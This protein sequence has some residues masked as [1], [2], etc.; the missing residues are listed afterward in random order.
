MSEHKPAEVHAK[1][2]MM[3]ALFEY[4]AACHVDN[5]L[6]ENPIEHDSSLEFA[7]PP[8]FDKKMKKIIARHD[9]KETLK[10]LRK[11]TIKYLPKAAIFLLVLIGS[12]TIVVA[13]VEALRVKAINIIYDMQ[14][15]FTSIRTTD[16]NNTKQLIDIPQDWNGFVPNYI[17]PGFRIDNAEESKMMKIISYKNEQGQSIVF[18]QYLNLNTDLRI[19]TEG[20]AVQNIT[21]QNNDALLSEKQGLISIAWKGEYLFSLIGV[22]DKTEM[23]KM[24]ESIKKK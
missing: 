1:E 4:A 19:D 3:E 24:A 11:K 22:A 20:A 21:V 10:A 6:D 23:L 18:T 13:S 5:I 15:Q 17:P 8:E 7:L 9:R 14:N 2:K 12:F 16:E